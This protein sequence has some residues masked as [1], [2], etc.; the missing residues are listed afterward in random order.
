MSQP[1]PFRFSRALGATLGVALAAT[2]AAQNTLSYRPSGA[3]SILREYPTASA[4]FNPAVPGPGVPVGAMAGPAAAFVGHPDGAVAVDNTTGLVFATNGAGVITRTF[5]PRLGCGPVPAPLAP[6][7]IPAAIGN[8][9]GMAFDPVARHL[10]LTNGIMIFEVDP[11]AGMAILCA[12]P[13]APLNVLSGLDYDPATPGLVYAVSTAGEIGTYQRCVGLIAIAP[14]TYAWP[15]AMAVGLAMDKSSAAGGM[16]YVL[17]ANGQTYNHS[18]GML[19]DVGPA[20][21]V[22]LSF[23][24]SPVNLPSAG[25]CGGVHPEA[26]V[27]ELAVQNQ[28][29]FGIDVCNLPAGT[30]F[31]VLLVDFGFIN[32]PNP[33]GGNTWLPI[34]ALAAF[35]HLVPAGSTEAHQ[36]LALPPGTA[37][38]GLYAQW[39]VPCGGAAWPY[40]TSDAMQIEVSR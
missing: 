22:G 18:L 14:P 17:H 21:R 39:F 10:F 15:G 37:G 2:V 31:A 38:L 30:P 4:A 13:Q 34:P 33:F 24:A 28:P 7:P 8:V 12:W 5:Y 9:T 25:L 1:F 40:I 11:A 27:S 35:F 6:L 29:A 26:R 3:T 16:W 20:N 23:L 36:P 32:P 19:H